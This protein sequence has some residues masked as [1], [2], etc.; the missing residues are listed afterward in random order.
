MLL[1][2]SKRR[3][4]QTIRECINLATHSSQRPREWPEEQRE[5]LLL[6]LL[7]RFSR[8]Q[9]CATPSTAAHHAPTSLGFSRQE[10]W[11]GLPFPS[12]E[13]GERQTNFSTG[14][15]L[16]F[17]IFKLLL[18]VL[19]LC[20]CSWAF[21]NCS[22]WELFYTFGVWISHYGS[23]SGGAWALGMWAQ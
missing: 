5:E 17:L 23:F 1:G 18:A 9:L 6:L 15:H 8:V 7:S 14:F 19:G 2:R 13:G 11:S 3:L 10:H 16:I 20:A 22:K 21:S 4:K 12:P